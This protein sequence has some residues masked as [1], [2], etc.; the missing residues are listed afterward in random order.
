M[1]TL[2]PWG[3]LSGKLWEGHLTLSELHFL[4]LKRGRMLTAALGGSLHTYV[5]LFGPDALCMCVCVVLPC[6]L[7]FHAVFSACKFIYICLYMLKRILSALLS[8]WVTHSP[9]HIDEIPMMLSI[10]SQFVLHFQRRMSTVAHCMLNTNTLCWWELVSNGNV[11]FLFDFRARS[12]QTLDSS[13]SWPR[14]G[15]RGRS[16]A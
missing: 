13:P 2:N 15:M 10:Q 8:K 11:K 14:I 3:N 5:C 7:K 6:K 9:I 12:G 16:L 4:L 1:Q